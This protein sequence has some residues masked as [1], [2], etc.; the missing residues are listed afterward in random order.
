[1]DA[2]PLKNDQRATALINVF[3]A[4]A[5]AEL[6]RLH[7]AVALRLSEDKAGLNPEL[8]ADCIVYRSGLVGLSR[9]LGER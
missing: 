8:T 4:R 2:S 3:A 5:A 7:A 1:M 6:E 9:Y